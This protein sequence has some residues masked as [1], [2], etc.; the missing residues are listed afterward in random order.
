MTTPSSLRFGRFEIRP[1]ERRVLEGERA[2]A[3]GARAFDVLLTLAERAGG[4]VTKAELMDQVWPGLVV[5]EN[6]LAVQVTTLRKVLG[7]ETIATIPGRGY[8]FTATP[9]SPPETK[10]EPL[11]AASTPAGA[12]LFGR[13]ADLALLG[14]H[15]ETPGCVTMVGTAGVGKTRL[16]KTIAGRWPGRFVWIDLAATANASQVVAAAGR[17]LELQLTDA[18]P[19]PALARALRGDR[20]LVVLDNAEHV[21][22]AVASLVTTIRQAAPHV[23]VLVTSQLPLSIDGERVDRIEPL[24]LR[25]A[26][27]GGPEPVHD[28]AVALLVD[29]IAASDHRFEVR[30]E[31]LPLLHD[32]CTRL[33]GLPLALEMAAARVPLLGL[34][35][36]RDALNQRFALLTT[37][38]RLAPGRHKTLHAAL[39]WSYGLLGDDEQRLLRTL[40]VFS[41]GFTLD[42]MVAVASTETT[43]SWS[44]IDRLAALVDRSLVAGSADDPPRY[45]LLE[46]MRAYALEKL[47]ALG[48]A[49]SARRRHAHAMLDLYLRATA[50]RPADETRKLRLLALAEVDNLRDAV[51]WA[52]RHEPVTAVKLTAEAGRICTFTTWRNEALSWL[53]ACEP[54]IDASV[55]LLARA[56]W[57]NQYSRHLLMSWHPAAL[58]QARK[59]LAL[60]REAADDLA[61]FNAVVVV[62]RASRE[63]GAELDECCAEMQSL[64]DA[65]PE[66]PVVARLGA[67]GALAFAEVV[68]GDYEKVLAHRLAELQIAR[69]AGFEHEADVA[70]S[71]IVAALEM[72]GR[73][74]EALARSTA[75]LARIGASGSVN[76]AYAWNSHIGMLIEAGDLA[77]ARAC[78]P[79]AREVMKT[80]DLPMLADRMALLAAKEGRVQTA[81]RLIGHARQ[82]YAAHSTEPESDVRENMAKA[83]ALCRARLDEATYEALVEA[84]RHLDEPTVDRLRLSDADDA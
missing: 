36:V 28:G 22:E 33:D 72:L 49:Q 11:R 27:S 70:E 35:G 69:N 15:L 16:A 60:S 9:A 81:A 5:E 18:D 54:L 20:V 65:H 50:S 38:H 23:C 10:P 67:Q 47:E 14:T 77:A 7:A 51:T 26:A 39:D 29:R 82:T 17:S 74:D 46:T 79:R 34:Q 71:N 13:D 64:L 80:Y 76:S 63:P 21:I 8:R 57:A 56:N 40:G 12:R 68:R 58:A 32:I 3:L 84:G 41:G 61:R 2:V 83:E 25:P 52:L 73:K 30:P 48:E 59:A 6:N 37:G 19:G 31:M 62:V 75:L 1:H 42:L 53:A 45:H 78:F 66:W 4:L 24:A 44:I 55:P 43:D